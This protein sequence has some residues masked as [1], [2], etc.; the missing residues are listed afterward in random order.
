MKTLTTLSLAALL[1]LAPQFSQAGFLDALFGAPQLSDIYVGPDFEAIHEPGAKVAV[2]GVANAGEEDMSVERGIILGD[3]VAKSVHRKNRDIEIENPTNLVKTL[4]QPAMEDLLK[5]FRQNTDLD[6]PHLSLIEQ[7]YP[8]ASHLLVVRID[9][10]R[11]DKDT[12]RFEFSEKKPTASASYD[13]NGKLQLNDFKLEADSTE[14]TDNYSTS[15]DMAITINIFDL[16]KSITV[17]SGHVHKRDTRTRNQTRE[18]SANH[19]DRFKEE[20]VEALAGGIV[21]GI[22]GTTADPFPAPI[23]TEELLGQLLQ[24]FAQKLP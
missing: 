24:A 8:A 14:V 16:K 7:K 17:W 13:K 19:K 12:S 9:R 1:T 23:P 6:L 15:R 10:N 20:L 4:G 11:I 22:T 5:F 21:S 2:L 3:L 18:Y